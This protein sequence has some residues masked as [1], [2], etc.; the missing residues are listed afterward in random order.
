MAFRRPGTAGADP[1]HTEAV[2]WASS[3]AGSE[4]ISDL[5]APPT[6]DW[7]PGGYVVNRLD[8]G[9]GQHYIGCT[10]ALRRR[11]G[12][13]RQRG[14][15]DLRR[16]L[17]EEKLKTTILYRC[18]LRELVEHYKKRAIGAGGPSPQPPSKHRDSV[19]RS[20]LPARPIVLGHDACVW[21]PHHPYI[22]VTTNVASRR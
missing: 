12:E 3:R 15:P 6:S 18:S 11:L 8:F 16:L 7:P 14:I 9:G 13:H 20:A 19:R 10:N 21:M 1:C 5:A 4:R 22:W 2:H 17:A